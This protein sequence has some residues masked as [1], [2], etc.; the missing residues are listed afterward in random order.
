MMFAD[1]RGPTGEDGF[2]KEVSLILMTAPEILQEVHIGQ[3]LKQSLQTL[4]R[5]KGPN[6]AHPDQQFSDLSFQESLR[7]N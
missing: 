6:T 4:R 3:F 7:G 2:K 1:S 5:L